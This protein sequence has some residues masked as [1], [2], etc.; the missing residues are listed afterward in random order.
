[1]PKYDLI[2]IGDCTTDAFIKLHD[3]SVHCDLNHKNCQLCMSFADKV[4]YESLTVVP[5]VGNSSNVAVGL[6]RLGVRSASFTTIG[7]DHYGREILE[8]YRR[9][10]VGREF[11]KINRNLPTN[12]HFVLNFRAE[13]TILIKHNTYQYLEPK[14]I[15]KVP[16]IYFSSMGEHALPFHHKLGKYLGANPEIKMGFNPGTFQLKLGAAKLREI[17][18]HTHV[19][20][21]NREEAQRILSA[22]GGPASSGKTAN[23]KILFKGLH[24]LGPKIVAI[25][26]GPAGAYASNG[27]EHYFI[28]I[29]PD[30]KAPLERTGAGDAFS[31]GFMAALIYNLPIT[32]ALSWAPV[33]SM[34]V[35]QEIGAQKGLL[36]K[37]QLLR[38]LKL[39]PRH[40]HPKQI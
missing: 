39:A 29:Y 14:K 11:V 5:G 22:K 20:F 12:Y 33:N 10:K 21:V 38:F 31:S 32:T 40:Y 23:V 27:Q 24:K 26:D 13:R 8:V 4:P 9:E 2:S 25:T 7:S 16:W 37:A 34:A 28:P 15:G 18:R 6:A 19:L 36:T 30:P 35:V 1:M 17:Y 3:A